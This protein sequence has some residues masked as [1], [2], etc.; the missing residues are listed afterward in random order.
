MLPHNKIIT[1]DRGL[2]P[3]SYVVLMKGM[4]YMITLNSISY[5]TALLEL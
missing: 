2:L 4:R 3:V 1:L 5:T